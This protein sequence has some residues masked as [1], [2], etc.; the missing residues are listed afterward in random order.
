M[1]KITQILLASFFLILLTGC[2]S[3]DDG[4]SGLS[5]TNSFTVTIDNVDYTFNTFT[6]IK[7]YDNYEVLG[8][9]DNQENFYLKFNENGFLDRANFYSTDFSLDIYYNSA[10]YY[11]INSFTLDNVIS[12]DSNNVIQADFNGL[13]YED[14]LDL[15][16]SSLTVNQGSFNLVYTEVQQAADIY[17]DAKIN[18][19]AYESV[20]YS[21]SS[22]GG[23]DIDLGGF[24]DGEL[25]LG[26]KFNPNTVQPGTFNFSSSDETN[27]ITIEY[28]NPYDN[29]YEN[30]DINGTLVIE[31]VVSGFPSFVKGTFTATATNNAG[32]TYTISDGKYN[33][34]Y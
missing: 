8:S 19:E 17:L 22:N 5:T 25:N 24:S 11:P 27:S 23:S 16:S 20:K 10:F 34:A 2:S 21:Q 30:L 28:V 13:I 32:N 7:N 18:G 6:A 1:K 4:G 33:L 9:N 3:S 15:T 26:V 31:E 14:D 29:T 12:D